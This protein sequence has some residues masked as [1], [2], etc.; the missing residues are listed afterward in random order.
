M[1]SFVR[2][3]WFRA[4]PL[5][6]VL[7]CFGTSLPAQTRSASQESA[8]NTKFKI[9]GT[10][11]NSITGAPLGKARITLMD[12]A[13]RANMLSVITAD[14]G[15][16]EFYSLYR[17]KYSLEGARRGFISAA[18]EQHEQFST[19]IVTGP[20]FNTENLVFRLTPLAF[21]SGR[22]IDETGEPVRKANVILYVE[23]HQGG[24][25]RTV[26]RGADTT[27][28]E[29]YYEFS[30][31]AP[32][33]YF[34]SV[35][36]KPW[37]AFHS[38]PPARSGGSSSPGISPLDVGYPTTYNNGATDSQSATPFPLQAGD[39]VQVDVHLSPV[40]VV[41]LTFRVPQDQQQFQMPQLQRRVFDTVEY[42]EHE[43][44]QSIAPGVYELGG[45]PAGKYSVLLPDS[46][47]GRPQQSSEISLDKDG[48]ELDVSHA[49]AMASLKLSVKMPR[50]APVSQQVTVGLQDSR[51]RIIAANAIDASGEVTLEGIPPGKYALVAFSPDSAYSVVRTVFSGVETSDHV[52]TL[53]AG[54][55]LSG[56]VFLALGVVAV[57][58][59]VHRGGKPSSGVM[60]ALIPKDPRSHLD[61]FRRDQSDSDGSF[62]LPAVIPGT[63][64]LIAVEDAWGF[65]WMQPDVL[66]RYL[67]HG[68]NLTIGELMTNSVH[69]PEP[70]E[71]QPR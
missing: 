46:Q 18:Y 55:S 68:Q 56:T 59:F 37:Y 17:A 35:S 19:A 23:N 30:A 39:H 12:T 5:A 29:G 57:E 15:H 3:I 40:P 21:V 13:N 27:D 28:D 16:F 50:Q 62:T 61:M 44:M 41:H 66:N 8:A 9:A 67:Q 45:V 54:S 63:Y 69:L 6:L 24:M 32:G 25:K 2:S 10:V 49:E 38:S 7:P 52:L 36:A 31:L 70:V 22:V 60:V 11:V 47:S 33:N 20:D 42:V 14:D 64:T 4:L 51:I 53:T 26:R 48:Q 1:P 58:G 34:V 65:Q 43:G 71:V